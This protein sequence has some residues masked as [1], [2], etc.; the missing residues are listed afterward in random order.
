MKNS[1]LTCLITGA[2]SGFG[3]AIAKTLA[4]Q[5]YQLILISNNYER[6]NS[7]KVEIVNEI[8]NTDIEIF[9]VDLSLQCE[10]KLFCAEFKSRFKKLDLLINNAGVNIPFKKQTSEGFEYMFA[11]NYLAPVLLTSLLLEKIEKSENGR[12][13]NI[14][15]NGEKFAVLDF[16]NLQGEKSFNGMS[17]YCITKLCLLMYTYE[18]GEKL[19]EKNISA[20]CLHPGGIRTAIMNNYKRYSIPKIAWYFLYPFLKKPGKASKY[21][22]NLLNLEPSIIHGKYFFKEKPGKSSQT[23]LNKVLISNLWEKTSELVLV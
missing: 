22:L 17:Q 7:V 15:S 19:I 11:V 6:L 18:L 4:R 2:D 16:E 12:I 5:E 3:K 13:I 20:C 1:G 8:Q 23:S 10:I 9:C 14:G 21:I